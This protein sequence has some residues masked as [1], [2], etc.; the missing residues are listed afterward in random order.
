MVVVAVVRCLFEPTDLRVY[1]AE[2]TRKRERR[3]LF[4]KCCVVVLLFNVEFWRVKTHTSPATSP[5]R[6]GFSLW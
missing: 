4:V 5:K 3:S 2:V 1:F 6:V